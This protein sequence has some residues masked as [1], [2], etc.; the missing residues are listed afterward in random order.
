M[1]VP[2]CPACVRMASMEEEL[3]NQKRG[4]REL[5]IDVSSPSHVWPT[6]ENCCCPVAMLRNGGIRSVI[7]FFQIQ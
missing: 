1:C 3:M 5:Q 6:E 7:F 2:V 4:H